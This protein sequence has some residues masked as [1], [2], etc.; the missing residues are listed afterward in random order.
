MKH[1]AGLRDQVLSTAAQIV[2]SD[3]VDALSMRE[4]ARKAGVSHQAP[5]HYFADREAILAAI[6]TEGF[7]I[8]GQRVVAALDLDD[9]TCR[10]FARAYV[11]TALEFPG[12]FRVM[13]QPGLVDMHRH[14]ETTAASSVAFTALLTKSQMVGSESDT[15]DDIFN[16]AISMWSFVH[17]LSTLVIDGALAAKLPDGAHIATYIDGAINAFVATLNGANLPVN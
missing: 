14:L 7:E 9:P 16:R 2:A 15:E 10:L 13:F 4:V 11:D 3:G 1:S 5:Y 6:A 12:H 8:L 17:G